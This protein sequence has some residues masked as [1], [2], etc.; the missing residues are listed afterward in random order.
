VA[1]IGIWPGKH[2]YWAREGRELAV[3]VQRR[4]TL[5]GEPAQ[6]RLKEVGLRLKLSTSGEQASCLTK[7]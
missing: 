2:R 1:G 6:T 7:S 5:C 4:L 3:R